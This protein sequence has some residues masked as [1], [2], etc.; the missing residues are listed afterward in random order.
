M[1]FNYIVMCLCSVITLSWF[2]ISLP[3][4]SLAKIAGELCSTCH[5]MH[6]SQN[7]TDMIYDASY[8][9]GT[10]PYPN[11]LRVNGCLGC[12]AATDGST[13][14]GIGGAPIVFNTSPPLYGARYKDEAYQ[15]LAGGNFYWVYTDD[16]KGHNVFPGLNSLKH[17]I[18]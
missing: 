7:G 16:T 17:R 12:H 13:W 8:D 3:S 1:H 10:G 14:Q 6:N 5:T 4:S 15:G 11:L 18:P 9:A 2:V